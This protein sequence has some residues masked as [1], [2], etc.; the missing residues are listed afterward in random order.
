MKSFRSYI[1]NHLILLSVLAGLFLVTLVVLFFVEKETRSSTNNLRT[2]LG[3]INQLVAATHEVTRTG[4]PETRANFNRAVTSARERLPQGSF[5]DE[6]ESGLR[7]LQTNADPEKKYLLINP[8]GTLARELSSRYYS[9]QRI[10]NMVLIG[11]GSILTFLLLFVLILTFQIH[12]EYSR[13]VLRTGE[14]MGSIRNLLDSE[15]RI[16]KFSPRWQEELDLLN[17]AGAIEE[18]HRSNLELSEHPVY[19]TLEAFIPKV[20]AILSKSVP[21]DRLAVAFIDNSDHIIAESAS[22]NLKSAYLEPGF[23]SLISETSLGEILE[24][25]QSRV[26][27]DLVHYYEH[28]HQSLATELILQEGVQSNL[29]IPIEIRGNIL[30]FL[31]LS[32]V[33]KNAFTQEHVKYAERVLNLLKQNLFF[34]YIIQQ[35]VAQ[36]TSAF[37]SLMERKDNETSLHITRM[38][39]Y[40]YVIARELTKSDSNVSPMLIREIFW[41]APLHDIG[42]IGV[43]DAILQ[44]NS[45]LE[46]DERKI[47]EEHVTIGLEVI[48]SM[49]KGINNIL[50]LTMLNTAENIIASH[51]EKYDGTGYPRGLSGEEIPIEGRIIALADVFDALTSKRPY[52]EAYPIS[53]A[54]EIIQSSIGTHFDPRV[55][56]AFL[57]AMPEIRKIYNRYKEI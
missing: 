52:K 35:I 4:T 28:V 40:S 42:K 17:A 55:H 2:Q 32:S 34:H 5:S 57:E 13:Y 44:K 23:V 9:L 26:I 51:H 38:S 22:S 12:R 43:P 31:F 10:H 48:R 46:L 18:I 53:K 21:C 1:K 47:I 33:E 41:F 27:N 25:R 56:Q 20:R 29:T 45:G 24:T 3:T 8:L 50:E 54:L 14:L 15:E 19:G 49:N 16:D 39:S 30:G 37:V 11:F 7:I 6:I 36:T